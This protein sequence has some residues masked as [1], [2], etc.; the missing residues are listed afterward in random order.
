MGKHFMTLITILC[1][2]KS[3]GQD[4]ND[5]ANNFS[6]H[7][8]NRPQAEYAKDRNISPNDNEINIIVEDTGYYVYGTEFSEP[9]DVISKLLEVH[10]TK[11]NVVDYYHSIGIQRDAPMY[12]L[13]QLL[14][15]LYEYNS[16]LEANDI[17]RLYTF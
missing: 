3:F 17:V 13:T 9:E 5:C 16:Q 12:A 7:F 11:N 8:Y 14:C 4:G 10:S 6:I 1:T 15:E 2:I